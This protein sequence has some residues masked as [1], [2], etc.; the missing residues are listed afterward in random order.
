MT[1]PDLIRASIEASSLSARRFAEWILARDERTIRRWASGDIAIPPIVRLW[2]ERWLE[3][4]DA[5][6]VRIVGTLS[7]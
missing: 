7:G 3:L 4:S 5:T 2:L 1:D 6:R